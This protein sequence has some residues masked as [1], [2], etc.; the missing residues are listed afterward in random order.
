MNKKAIT[1]LRGLKLKPCLEELLNCN[2][3]A[4]AANS[5]WHGKRCWFPT[6]GHCC[7]LSFW[8]LKGLNAAAPDLGQGGWVGLGGRLLGYVC[9]SLLFVLHMQRLLKC[10]RWWGEEGLPECNLGLYSVSGNAA[11]ASV[12]MGIHSVCPELLPQNCFVWLM[13]GTLL[14]ISASGWDVSSDTAQVA[15]LL[16]AILER[17]WY[18]KCLIR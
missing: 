18:Q 17:T 6:Y 5:C 16:F 14:Q 10:C 15:L 8:G 12:P 1:K 9:K 11:Q 7:G 13:P 4:S 3:F 2:L